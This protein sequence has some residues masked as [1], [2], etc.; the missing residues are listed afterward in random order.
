MKSYFKFLSRN[1]VYTFI[2]AFGIAFALGF[3]ILLLS[4]AKTEYSV[5]KNIRGADNIYVLGNGD[6]FGMTL[7]TPV[8]FFAEQSGEA[9]RESRYPDKK[10]FFPCRVA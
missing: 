4:Y 5:G 3:I 1:K 7:D 10:G 8:E 2:E 6:M 9:E